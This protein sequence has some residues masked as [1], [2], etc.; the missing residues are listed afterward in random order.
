MNTLSERQLPPS[1]RSEAPESWQGDEALREKLL[2]F[3]ERPGWSRNALAKK[4]GC[5][6]A[7]VSCYLS[8]KGIVAHGDPAKF[9]RAAWD[10]IRNEERRRSSGI[11]TAKCDP[12][13]ELGKMFER[14]RRNNALAEILAESGYGK[15]RGVELYTRENPTTIL[16]T[17]RTWSRDVKSIE[18]AMMNAVGRAGYD[19]RT[20]RAEF[21]VKKMVGSNRLILVDNAEYLTTPA[22]HW[23]YDFQ[24]ETNCPMALIGTFLLCDKL[25]CDDRRSSRTFL[26]FELKPENPQKLLQHLIGQ[27]APDAN[28]ETTAIYDLCEQIAEQAGHFRSVYQ[29]LKLAGEMRSGKKDMSWVTAIKAAHTCLIRNYKLN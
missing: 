6:S 22:L 1:D 2:Q 5:N 12:T 28:G 21:M 15:T 4:I 17:V 10:F 19:N 24:E 18:G 7:V 9:E 20:K 29:Q 27:L 16:Y 3:C 25:E 13:D 23:L 11:T 14:T 8:D 26:R